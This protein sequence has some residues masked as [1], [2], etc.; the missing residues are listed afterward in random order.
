MDKRKKEYLWTIGH[1]DFYLLSTKYSNFGDGK[2]IHVYVR[3]L[4]VSFGGKLMN[5]DNQ[6]VETRAYLVNEEGDETRIR[7]ENKF[8]L[9]TASEYA[10]MAD[11][12]FW[13]D[14]VIPKEFIGLKEIK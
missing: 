1:T 11:V 12:F 3:W 8:F 13:K 4:R 5:T 14:A 10:S 9:N 2:I 7:D 6:Y